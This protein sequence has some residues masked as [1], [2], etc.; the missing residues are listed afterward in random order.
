MGKST[1]DLMDE[2]L[3]T[4]RNGKAAMVKLAL[5]NAW[6]DAEITSAEQALAAHGAPTIVRDW[7]IAR[8]GTLKD[9]RGRLV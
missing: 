2:N 6:V 4:L 3:E 8:I 5:L 7:A 9:V 1:L